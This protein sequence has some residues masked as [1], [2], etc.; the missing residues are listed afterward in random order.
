MHLSNE[1]WTAGLCQERKLGGGNLVPIRHLHISDISPLPPKFWITF[2]FH[3]S[4]E[5]QLSQEKLKTMF[6]QNFGGQIRCIMGDVQAG[7]S[8]TF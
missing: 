2:V 8:G 5:L 6:I 7:Y 1:V 3:F 4:L